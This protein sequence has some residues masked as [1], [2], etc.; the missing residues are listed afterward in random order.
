MNRCARSLPLSWLAVAVAGAAAAFS[1]AVLGAGALAVSGCAIHGATSVAGAPARADS[2]PPEVEALLGRMTLDEKIGQMTQIDRN[3]LASPGDIT[4]FFLGSILNGG[5][6]LPVPNQAT[7]WADSIDAFQR[8]ALATRLAIPILYGTD[9]VHGMGGV[10]GAVIFPHNVGLGCTRDPALVERVARTAALEV[11]GAGARWAFAPCIAVP[12][13]GRWGRTYEGFGETPDLVSEMGPAVVRGLQQAP[14]GADGDSAVLACA[15]H[16][17]ADGGTTFGKDQGDAAIS[18]AELRAIHLPGY[19][20]AVKAGVGSV[21]VSYSSWNGVPMHANRHLITDVLKGE[22]GFTGFVV[23]DWEALNKLPGDYSKQVETG[24]NAG[25]DM[26]MVPSNYRDFIATMKELVA[27]GRIPTARIDDAVRRILRQKVRFGLWEHP[28]ADRRLTAAIG[29]A[30]H[31]EIARQ[32]VRE[33]LVLLKNERHALPL[34]K[35]ALINVVGAKADDIGA[36]CGGWTVGWQGK[37][38]AI[39]PGT[40]I[41]EAIRRGAGDPA[42][43]TFSGDQVGPQAARADVNVVVVGEEP[44]AEGRGDRNIPELTKADGELVA[45]VAAAGKPVVLLLLTGRPLLIGGAF[46]RADAV[47]VAWLP[48]SEGEGVAD[49]LYGDSPPTGKLSRTWPRELTQ[50]PINQGEAATDPLFPYG[51]GL[52]Y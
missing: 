17:L 46:R 15:K 30:P 16:F 11:A 14:A 6:S 32:A 51:F 3:A 21:M 12:R 29:S 34:S 45:E 22:L 36:Q 49:V 40:T 25:I 7:V 35:A 31:R 27:A 41:L 39:T 9:A 24:I 8:A 44:Y 10:R 47:V 23:T 1:V 50:I 38:G 26:V 28:F 5:E 2:Q 13:D 19:A 48:G 33:S 4:E 18:E 52:G 43:V 37:R 42:K 20:A